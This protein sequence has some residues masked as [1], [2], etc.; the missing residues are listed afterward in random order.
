MSTLPDPLDQLAVAELARL[1]ARIRIANGFRTDAGEFVLTEE[2]HGDI[3][4]DVMSLEIADDDEET[5][6]QGVKRRRGNL[7]VTIFVNL[8]RQT[9]TEAT[10]SIARRVLADIRHALAKPDL[11]QFP[12]GVTGLEIGGRSMQFRDA[13]SQY[14]RPQLRVRISFVETH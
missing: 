1:L 6:Y 11:Y 14:F 2:N 10:R 13:G 12:A 3:T 4:D 9:V 7:A 5:D 8:P